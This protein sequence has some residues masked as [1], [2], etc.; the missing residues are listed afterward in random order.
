[1]YSIATP[2]FSFLQVCRTLEELK[3]YINKFVCNRE[4]AFILKNGQEIGWIGEDLTQRIGWGYYI[5]ENIL[6]Y[7]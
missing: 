1:M 6:Q 3:P 2:T 5:D 4:E 7:H